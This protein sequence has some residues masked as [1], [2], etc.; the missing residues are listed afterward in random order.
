MK[1]RERADG[2]IYGWRDLNFPCMLLQRRASR[3]LLNHHAN[4]ILQLRRNFRS[5]VANALPLLPAEMEKPAPPYTKASDQAELWE[6]P[7][8]QV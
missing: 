8:K 4:Q 6:A 5:A 1:A 7:E 3:V 2:H